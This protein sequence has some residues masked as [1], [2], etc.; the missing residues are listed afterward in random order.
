MLYTGQS[1]RQKYW[2]KLKQIM[3]ITSIDLVINNAGVKLPVFVW[4]LRDNHGWTWYLGCCKILQTF[5]P[6]LGHKIKAFYYHFFL[7]HRD[8]LISLV[9]DFITLL[10]MLLKFFRNV[11]LIDVLI[12]DVSTIQ[13]DAPSNFQKNVTRYKTMY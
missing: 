13:F 10:N 1:L 6:V 7:L 8:L 2:V 12:W 3:K 9:V 5:I 4:R 11:W